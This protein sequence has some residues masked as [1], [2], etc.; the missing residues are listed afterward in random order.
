MFEFEQLKPVFDYNSI[1]IIED[2]NCMQTWQLSDFTK[3]LMGREWVKQFDAWA[4]HALPKQPACYMIGDRTMVTHPSVAKA[5]RD[6]VE[7]DSKV[8]WYSFSGYGVVN[9]QKSILDV[10]CTA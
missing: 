10:L 1:K 6:K 7:A 3:E 5:I 9:K 2:A 4:E 8:R